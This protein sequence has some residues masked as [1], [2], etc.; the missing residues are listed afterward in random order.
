MGQTVEERLLELKSCL[1]TLREAFDAINT[2]SKEAKA[3]GAEFAAHMIV[4]GIDSLEDAIIR[5]VERSQRDAAE[6]GL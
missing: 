6:E 5:Y 2:A 4:Q 1:S 3:Y